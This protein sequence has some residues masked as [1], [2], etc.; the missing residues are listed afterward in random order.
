MLW[1]KT[2]EK[3]WIRKE[4]Q[5]RGSA[6]LVLAMYAGVVDSDDFLVFIR[7]DDT[8]SGDFIGV[9]EHLTIPQDVCNVGVVMPAVQIETDHQ[10]NFRTKHDS[11]HGGISLQVSTNLFRDSSIESRGYLGDSW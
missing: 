8:P 6:K 11:G 3:V 7:L 10:H 4:P 5:S 9:V 2:G 1:I